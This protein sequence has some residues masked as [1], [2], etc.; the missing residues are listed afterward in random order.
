MLILFQFN[1]WNNVVNQQMFIPL[2]EPPPPPPPY[3]SQDTDCTRIKFNC[4]L[5]ISFPVVMS[6]QRRMSAAA[7]LFCN[8]LSHMTC[9]FETDR[10]IRI[11]MRTRMH[12]SRMRMARPLTLWVGGC[13]PGGC[14][15]GKAYHVTYPIMHL[16]LPVCCLLAN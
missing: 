6:L 2:P 10:C 5:S 14:L 8:P 9:Y 12:S 7:K 11:Y 4:I 15:P 1:Y 3:L 16:M 13:L